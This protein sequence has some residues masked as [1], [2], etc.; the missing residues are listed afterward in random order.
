MEIFCPWGG[1]V[2]GGTHNFWMGGWDGDG[3]FCT[4][5]VIFL[6]VLS[7]I[8]YGLLDS[9]APMGGGLGDPHKIS[10]KESFLT[11]Y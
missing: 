5:A 7:Y 6:I 8:S 4:L 2:H 9:M 3:Y 1:S 10:R 11:S